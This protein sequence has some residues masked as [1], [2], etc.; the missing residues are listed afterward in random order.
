[1][2]I[3]EDDVGMVVDLPAKPEVGAS[4]SNIFDSIP[5]L[6]PPKSTDLGN[7]VDRYLSADVENVTTNAIAWWHE[8]RAS[9]PRLPQLAMDYLTIPESTCA[10]LCLGAWSRL[11]LVKAEDMLK[12]ATLPNVQDDAEVELEDGWN[13]IKP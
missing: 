6:V 2:E 8:C 9:Y 7:E 5:T 4:C 13:R 1:M 11:N 10:L 3:E 12:V